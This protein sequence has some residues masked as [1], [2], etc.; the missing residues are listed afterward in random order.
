MFFIILLLFI[1]PITFTLHQNA[2]HSFSTYPLAHQ[3][4]NNKKLTSLNHRSTYGIGSSC[5]KSSGQF[6][7]TCEPTLPSKYVAR[8][9]RLSASPPNASDQPHISVNS[10]TAVSPRMARICGMMATRV[11]VVVVVVVVLD[12]CLAYHKTICRYYRYSNSLLVW[13]LHWMCMRISKR[14]NLYRL[15]TAAM[16]GNGSVKRI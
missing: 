2:T 10:V 4:T 14:H 3:P 11:V 8:R 16:F 9:F 1:H 12:G 7:T 5:G 15:Y 13:A 6:S